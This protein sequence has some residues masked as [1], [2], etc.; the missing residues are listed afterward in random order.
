M[1]KSLLFVGLDVHK[2]SIMIAVVEAG[3][4][5]AYTYG[6]QATLTKRNSAPIGLLLAICVALVFWAR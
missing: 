4:E 1:S 6:V 5:P 3:R 2:D